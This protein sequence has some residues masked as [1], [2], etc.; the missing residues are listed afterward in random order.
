MTAYLTDNQ[1]RIARALRELTDEAGYPPSIREIADA[2]ALS[3]STVAY[4]LQALERCGIVTHAP[5]RS[6]SYQMQ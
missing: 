4:H 5:H 3:A 1:R 2:V 6:R